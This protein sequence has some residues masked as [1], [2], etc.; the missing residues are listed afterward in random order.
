MGSVEGGVFGVDSFLFFDS[1]VLRLKRPP[2]KPERKIFLIYDFHFNEMKDNDH[3][4]WSRRDHSISQRKAPLLAP[5]GRR[6]A[7][8]GFAGYNSIS[9]LENFP[10]NPTPP[11]PTQTMILP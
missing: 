2:N 3:D 10:L 11:P 8:A 9:E 7:T 4:I 6:G 5:S 1:F